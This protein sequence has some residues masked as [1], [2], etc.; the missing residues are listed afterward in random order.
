MAGS[1]LA[2]SSDLV[3]FMAAIFHKKS[4][5]CDHKMRKP[6]YWICYE[7]YLKLAHN[8]S[9]TKNYIFC[10]YLTNNLLSY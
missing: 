1:G 6:K 9:Y 2:I 3:N 4:W 7:I 8:T 5:V 10:N